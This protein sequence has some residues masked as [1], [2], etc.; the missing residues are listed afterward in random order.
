M[1]SSSPN[2]S[3]LTV[4][5]G[6]GLCVCCC[7]AGAG[8]RPPAK[9][10]A[11]APTLGPRMAAPA[12]APRA[13]RDLGARCSRA[14]SPAP[15]CH[16]AHTLL[17]FRARTSPFLWFKALLHIA[18]KAVPSSPVLSRRC[19][20]GSWSGSGR[21]GSRQGAGATLRV[22]EFG[23]ALVEESWREE[24]ETKKGPTK[25]TKKKPA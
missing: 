6:L 21:A 17:P 5:A 12:P 23:A 8:A 7:A 24:E 1:S 2:S 11:P 9:H 13:P 19:C 4:A 18:D 16:S 25:T 14:S 20:N 10:A 3:E 15:K 22:A